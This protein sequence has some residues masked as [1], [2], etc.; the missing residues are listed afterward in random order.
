MAI[1][2]NKR[3]ALLAYCRID[4]PEP[5]ELALL[6]VLYDSAVAYMTQA[7]V[8]AP[9]DGTPRAAQY[10]LCVNAMV[11][12]AY[13][14]RSVSLPGAIVTDNPAFRRMLVQL[15]LTEPVSESDTGL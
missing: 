1:P 4:A 13:D 11:L 15:K 5:E 12:D 2:E 9:A 6:D 8:T 7:G 10:D 14:Q 3:P